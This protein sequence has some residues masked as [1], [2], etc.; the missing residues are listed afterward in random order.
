[1]R[2][3][4]LMVLIFFWMSSC[5]TNGKEEVSAKQSPSIIGTW[6]LLSGTTIKG[7][8]TVFTEYTKEQEMIKIINA[9]HFAFFRHDLKNGQ[10]STAFFIA[11]GGKY[12]LN[13]NKYTEHLEY[14][15]FREWENN[16]FELTYYLKGDSLI[17]RGIEKIESLNVNHVNIEKFIRLKS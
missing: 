4:S 9:S 7:Q 2:L 6:K 14:C 10:D 12:S 13:G 1:M 11:G 3:L 15:N 17:T 16:N 5:T 8:D